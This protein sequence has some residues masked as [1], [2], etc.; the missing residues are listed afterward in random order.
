MPRMKPMQKGNKNVETA[1][2]VVIK[3]PSRSA[4]RKSKKSE[5]KRHIV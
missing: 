2:S 4:S 5:R 1:R 3:R